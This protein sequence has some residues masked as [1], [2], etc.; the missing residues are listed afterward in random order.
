MSA[1]AV[2]GAMRL[3]ARPLATPLLARPIL[4]TLFSIPLAAAPALL[5]Q[6]RTWLLPSL[7][8]LLE[9]FPPF[10]LAVPKKKVS[11]SRKSMREANKGLKD[12]HNI[13]NCPASSTKA[14]HGLSAILQ[15]NP[16]DVVITFAQRSAIGR[17]KKGQLKDT[18]VDEL[19]HALFKA[20][21]EK[22]KLDP[23]K[24]DDICVGTCHPPSPLYVSRAAALAAGIPNYV[25]I[26]T[27]NRLC[28]S[29]LMAIRNI[30]HAIQAGETSIGLAVGV[31]SMSMHPRPTPQIC[32]AVD[33]NVDAHDC[34]QPMGW[35]S[36]MV[37]QDYN[38]SRETQDKYALISHTRASEAQA[39]GIFAD[40]IIPL[41]L[42]G[43]VLSVDD[44]IRPGVTAQSLAGLKPVWPDWGN[45]STTAGNAS[46]TGDGAGICILTTR[47][48]AEQE[49]ME[50]LAK[51]VTSSV[52]GCEPKYMG[53]GPIFAIPK[54]LEQAGLTKEDIDVY[55]I[56][57]AF[58][59]QFAYCVDQLAI[60][61]EKINPNG[62]AI[63]ISHPLGMTGVRQVVT[64][65]AELRRRNGSLLCTSMC[66]GSGMG[67]A[68]FKMATQISKKRKFV[69]DGVFRA[70][71]NEFFTRELAEEGYS[72]CDVRVT[73]ARTEIIIR[74]T[75]TQEV[76]G[77]KGRRIRELTALVQKR[78][79][80]P[81]N[82]LELYAEKVQY[83][84]L[85]AIAQC[86]SLRY[87]LLGGLAVL[88]ATVS[89]VSSWSPAQKLRAAR[90]KSMK[91]T[92][93]FMIHS[94]QPAIDFVDFAVRHVL[95][96]QGVL[97]IKVKIMKGTDPEGQM[98]PKKPLP[99][100]VTILEPPV[101]K[102][103]LEPTSEQREPVA[104]APPPAEEYAAPP[105]DYQQQ[106][107]EAYAEQPNAKFRKLGRVM[108]DLLLNDTANT[109]HAL[110]A[111]NIEDL[112]A[113][114]NSSDNSEAE[115]VWDEGDDIYRC[116]ECSW[117]LEHGE[118]VRCGL[119]FD[120]DL[121]DDADYTSNEALT[122]ERISLAR[123]DTPLRDDEI[124][125]L[126]PPMYLN[127]SGQI[128]YYE[129]RRRG[130][131]RLMCETFNL[132][133]NEETGIVAWADGDL[134][135]EF[136]GPRMEKGDF[137]KILLGRHI[138]LDDDDA[139]G[140]LFIEG[141]L[142]DTIV[143]PPNP[144]AWETV[145]ESSA[146][147]AVPVAAVESCGYETSDSDDEN[148]MAIDD[149]TIKTE[150]Q[151]EGLD[152]DEDDEGDPGW[153]WE[154]DISDASWSGRKR[155]QSVELGVNPDEET[156]DDSADSDFSDE[157]LSDA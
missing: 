54:V 109:Q 89:S 32:E 94:G 44:T 66:I 138:Q 152:M 28:S 84:G 7:Q 153:T 80:F 99:D 4:S 63:A 142:E 31:D 25:P 133:F 74:A 86:E 18:A 139:D 65:L 59:S 77:E 15:K 57:E 49:G 21:L 58:A 101:D 29:G 144:L 125:L 37:A 39:K 55:E 10:V 110:E 72:G 22:T 27:V 75:H 26:S 119:E 151:D 150:P 14:P 128:E 147:S 33:Q 124:Q 111:E 2:P 38:V 83:R 106:Q 23:S 145:E 148:N 143:F 108:R 123:G 88:H 127:S 50:V 81:E 126:P 16:D 6:S 100:S 64:G 46:G 20:T 135:T 156:D 13:V 97:G 132:E 78:F 157:V 154:A 36:E 107:P 11:H 40:E 8:S 122:A 48:R 70:E 12:K 42:K 112:E 104:V 68:D 79:K 131:T 76:L 118:C 45:G 141:L 146:E 17:M 41:E 30:A 69:A 87:K 51:W 91:F 52:V 90:A 102:V 9:L 71:L 137:W 134:Y 136:A 5:T 43:T 120:I 24:I 140:S 73:H 47:A 60:P 105:Q 115:A 116:P 93:G 103:V 155:K 56:N 98:G 67:A 117:E 82:S 129:L 34:I 61:I 92:D 95:L 62:G 85:S 35:T 96:R 113:F 1:L 53:L 114:L 121:R 3:F 19:L 130:A 149:G